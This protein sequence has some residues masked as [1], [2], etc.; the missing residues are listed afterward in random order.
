MTEGSLDS[1]TPVSLT[2]SLVRIR[3][4]NPSET[5]AECARFVADWFRQLGVDVEVDEAA[6]GRPNVVARVPGGDGPA[7]AYL[8]HMDTV[9]AGEGWSVDPFAGEVRDGRLYGRGAA[10]MK[11]GLAASMFALKRVVESGIALKRPFLVCATVDEEGA[12][13]Y[14]AVRLVERGLLDKDTLLVAPEPT[15]LDLVVAQ[16]GVMWYRAETWGRMSHAGTPHIG[17]DANHGL[18]LALAALKQRFAELPHDHPLLG[19]TSVTIG[20]MRGGTKTNVVPDYAWAEIDTR[21]VPPLTTQE[22]TRLVSAV[23][24]DAAAMVPGVRGS[25]AVVTI[26][27]P[28]VETD[29]RSPLLGAFEQAFREVTRRAIVRGGFPAYTDAAIAAAMTGNGNC[30]LFGPGHLTQ[31]HTADEFV[32]VE[33]IDVATA[34]LGRAAELLLTS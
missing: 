19:R 12:H 25:A 5:E 9:P 22:A 17:A 33:E 13:M 1:D 27:R 14:G 8:A 28:P 29:P 26:D 2:Q 11:S 32:P 3:S 24:E 30:V 7:L 10:D 21:L 31:A 20:Q 18:A 6:P 15:G 4:A 16:K 23:V 34:V